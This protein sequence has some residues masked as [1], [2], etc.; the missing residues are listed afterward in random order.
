[1]IAASR[2]KTAEKR[3]I[4]GMLDHPG[5]RRTVAAATTAPERTVAFENPK[6]D[7]AFATITGHVGRR[8]AHEP[9]RRTARNRGPL[10]I[11]DKWGTELGCQSCLEVEEFRGCIRLDRLPC[12]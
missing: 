2:G 1:M 3:G 9:G 5:R 11:T 4:A 7:A 8:V 6:R 10:R 12:A